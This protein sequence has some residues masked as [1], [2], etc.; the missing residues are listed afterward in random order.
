MGGGGARGGRRVEEEEDLAWLTPA[1]APFLNLQLLRFTEF[2]R[3]LAVPPAVCS[4]I[5][6][7]GSG[8]APGLRRF[9]LMIALCSRRGVRVS[10]TSRA[11]SF[12]DWSRACVDGLP[13]HSHHYYYCY[14]CYGC[15]TVVLYIYI[16]NVWTWPGVRKVDRWLGG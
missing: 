10:T 15:S 9:D 12:V 7:T 14:C 8:V 5:K 13:P 1:L 4:P 6:V 16:Y 2:Y 11:R 3:L